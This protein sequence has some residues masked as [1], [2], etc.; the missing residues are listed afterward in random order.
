M[1]GPRLVILADDLTGAA[2]SA[3]RAVRAGLAA[4]VLFDFEEWHML[5]ADVVAVTSDS[6]HLPPQEAADRV[7]AIARELAINGAPRDHRPRIYKKIDSTLR[8]NIGAELD[9]LLL[10]LGDAVPGVVICP[11]FPA[12]GR[13][14]A[15]GSLVHGGTAAQT[16]NLPRLLATQSQLPAAAIGLATVRRGSGT[17]QRALETARA[18]GSRLLVVDALTDDDLQTIVLAAEQSG[19]LLC[20][21]AGLVM[22]L[23]AYLAAGDVAAPQDPQL[24]AGPI[25]TVVGSGSSMAHRQVAQAARTRCQVRQVDGTWHTLD[26]VG[27]QAAPVG[28]W[29]IH[30]APPPPGTPLEGAPA[31]ARAAQLADMAHLAVKRLQPSALIIVGGDTAHFTLRALG[32]TR[33]DVVTE[34]LPGIPLTRTVDRQ[35]VYRY[36]VLKPG[37]FGDAGTL[38]TLHEALHSHM[39]EPEAAGEIDLETAPRAAE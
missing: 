36:V 16:P 31:R 26:L 22:P 14:L 11:A 37:S 10:A 39:V 33:L 29:L 17:L 7:E 5:A 21:S 18:E 1:P 13:G 32:I 4:T 9:G 23:A 35:G 6:R 12:Q 2:D 34:L 19:M 3:A 27:A 28:D 20:G 25:L 8:G 24:P 15:D 38:V 30:L